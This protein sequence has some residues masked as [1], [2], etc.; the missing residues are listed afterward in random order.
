MPGLIAGSHD[1]SGP[2]Q[3]HQLAERIEDDC[4]RCGWHGYFHHWIAT[5]G[6][7]WARAVC[8]NCFADLHPAITVTVGYFS[9][10]WPDDGE[11]VA[12]IRQRTAATIRSQIWGRC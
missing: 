12:V 10:C 3:R 4:P 1:P 11:P 7:D 9:A 5:I 6:A 2:A 8:D